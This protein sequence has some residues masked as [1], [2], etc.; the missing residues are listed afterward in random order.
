MTG[1]AT[2]R[3]ADFALFE[4]IQRAKVR[5]GDVEDPPGEK[6]TTLFGHLAQDLPSWNDYGDLRWDGNGCGSL[7]GNHYDWSLGMYLHFL[8]TGLLPFADAGRIF[9]SHEADLDVYH[10][11]A[12]GEAYNLQKDWED[13]PSHDSPDNCFGGGR[14]SHTWAQ[15]YALHWLLTGDRRGLDA[16]EEL[17]EGIRRYLFLGFVPEG[18]IDTNE[19]RIP[20]WIAENLLAL[21]RVDPSRKIPTP[22]GP[23]TIP[24]VLKAVLEG[25]FEREAAAGGKGFVYA[26]VQGG[27]EREI[28]PNLRAPLQHLYFL[29]PVI[30]V[31]LELF[32]GR[33]TAY[34]SRLL[35]LCD[36]MTRW[37]VSVTYGGDTDGA[38]RYRPRQIPDAFDVRRPIDSQGRGQVPYGILAANAAAAVYL[39]TGDPSLLSYARLAFSDAVRYYGVIGPDEYGDPSERTAASY[40]L[41]MFTGTESKVQGWTSRYGQFVLA[42][43]GGALPPCVPSDVSPCRGSRPIVVRPR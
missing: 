7:S 26:S 38:G 41:P 5:L 16:F 12:D 6:G 27:T 28:D 40:R 34:A 21:W 20:G 3:Q 15:G 23:R 10:T 43:E 33:D 42:V 17:Q 24:E 29:E 37:I 2:D 13:R 36:R 39:E 8:R 19:L 4:K 25:V 11:T 31:Y 30:K 22:E 35:G 9:A 14:P 1:L 32:K 18:R